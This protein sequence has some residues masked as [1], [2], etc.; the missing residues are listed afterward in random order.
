MKKLLCLLVLC[1][2]IMVSGCSKEEKKV[3]N[4]VK[5]VENGVYDIPKDP[6]TFQSKLFN[7][8]SKALNQED[9]SKTASLVAQNFACDFFT[10]INKESSLDVGGLTYLPQDRQE[11]FKTFAS[12][13]VYG[14]YTTFVKEEGKDELPEINAIEEVDVNETELSYTIEVP[15]NA[16]AGVDA[17]SEENMYR[18]WEVSLKLSYEKSDIDESLLKSEVLVQVIDLD[19]RFVVIGIQ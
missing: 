12:S 10:L 8:L 19:G 11:E 2:G 1:M 16:E 9:D 18:G 13:Y 3:E 5:I 6:S 14:N 4:K 15:A 17:Y 7:K